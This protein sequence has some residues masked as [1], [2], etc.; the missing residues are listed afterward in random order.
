MGGGEPGGGSFGFDGSARGC[1]VA[2]GVEEEERRRGRL[3]RCRAA[4]AAPPT[5]ACV[6]LGGPV[7]SVVRE[8]GRRCGGHNWAKSF[9]LCWALLIEWRLWSKMVACFNQSWTHGYA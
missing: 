2:V 1:G 5:E 8:L 4:A 3:A 7:I 6:G 9:G